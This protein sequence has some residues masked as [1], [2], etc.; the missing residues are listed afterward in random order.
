MRPAWPCRR[1]HL[2]LLL[3]LLLGYQPQ[4]P[5][6]QMTDVLFEKWK[7]YEDQCLHNLSLLPPP[8]ELVCNRT[9]DKYSCWP[10]TPPNT[11]ARISCPWYLPWHH[12]VQHRFVF[13]RCGPD[14]QWAREPSRNASQCLDEEEVAVQMERRYASFQVMYTV[15]YSLSLGALLLALLIL[16]GLSKL[17]CMRN[18]IHANLFLSFVL[19]ASSVLVID[20]LLESRYHQSVGDDQSMSVWL[21]DGVS[22]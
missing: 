13:K 6:A 21:S 8:T 1:P 17:H 5:A 19:R 4:A 16:L 12:K 20:R 11:T 18:F 15:G 3:Q 14:G 7:L 9:F 2:L 10:D 22:E